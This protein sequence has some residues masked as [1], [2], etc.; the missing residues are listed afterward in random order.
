MAIL[1]FW[2]TNQGEF[3]LLFSSFAQCYE[4]LLAAQ[5]GDM[6]GICPQCK[7]PLTEVSYPNKPGLKRL[8][9][10]G[11]CGFQVQSPK[12][13][14]KITVSQSVRKRGSKDLV[15]IKRDIN[16]FFVNE[17]RLPAIFKLTWLIIRA[18]NS[19]E[20][21]NL[22]IFDTSKKKI[23][24]TST[25]R[26]DRYELVDIVRKKYGF[27]DKDSSFYL[28]GSDFTVY[29]KE[30]LSYIKERGQNFLGVVHS[31]SAD[32]TDD[33]FEHPENELKEPSTEKREFDEAW[34]SSLDDKLASI[35][36]T[37]PEQYRNAAHFRTA[38]E[39]VRSKSD[40]FI[41]T[42]AEKIIPDFDPDYVKVIWNNFVDSELS[43]P[44]YFEKLHQEAPKPDPVKENVYIYIDK[45]QLREI[46]AMDPS[47]F[48]SD[49][50]NWTIAEYISAVKK[51]LGIE[52][53]REKAKEFMSSFSCSSRRLEKITSGAI[54]RALDSFEEKENPNSE[55]SFAD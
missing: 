36:K 51:E 50:V 13:R 22:G 17:D 44:K 18:Q 54:D 30:I 39:N 48:G 46:Y 37:Y 9:C 45:D 10:T 38:A 43:V 14:M 26:V 31:V 47:S 23:Q 40:G 1:E 53:S 21:I 11:H 20:S 34:F 33:M 8:A 6:K 55:Y 29:G 12:T 16:P 19:L 49:E 28:A 5:K 27:Y 24:V 35:V 2:R 32:F 4:R 25:K 42:Q 52:L 7:K 41:L 3:N 15:T